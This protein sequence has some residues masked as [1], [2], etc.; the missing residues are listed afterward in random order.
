MRAIIY[1]LYGGLKHYREPSRDEVVFYY[2]PRSKIIYPLDKHLDGFD[3]YILVDANIVTGGTIMKVIRDLGLEM[4]RVIIRGNPKTRLAE[5]IVDEVMGD[6]DPDR[7]RIAIGFAGKAAS[8]KSFF[9]SALSHI[10]G[11]PM[12][13]I[14]KELAKRVDV[15]RYGEKLFDV[16]RRNPFVVG[17][18]IF[19]ILRRV[20][21]R[22]VIIDGLKTIETARFLSYATRRAMYIFFVE[23]GD[24]ELRRLSAKFRGDPDDRFFEERD[25][26]FEENLRKLREVSYAVID[27]LDWTTLKPLTELIRALGYRVS[28][29]C[30]FPNPFGSKRPLLEDYRRCVEKMVNGCVT[31]DT[32][33]SEYAFHTG[34]IRRLERRG[35]QLNERGREVV[36][37][38]ASA[39]R[40]VDDIL[41]EHR[42]RKGMPTLWTNEGIMRVIYIAILMTVKAYNICGEMG[43]GNKFMEMFRRVV[44]AVEYEL[45]VEDGIEVF[46]KFDD[47]LRAAEREAAFREFLA[48]L[49]GRQDL[50]NEFRAWGLRAQADDDLYDAEDEGRFGRPLFRREWLDDLERYIQD[51]HQS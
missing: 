32:D 11:I 22:V 9:A 44:N 8:M 4:E 16:E 30:G 25:S 40:I 14:G 1:I 48:H 24:E 27:S 5:G 19:P 29:I 10:H 26:L 41:D 46:D 34:Y 35:I 50:I 47:W 20:E 36:M 17:E 18:A 12:I 45:L 37:L 39:F 13:K 28:T 49:C 15:G 23:L 6:A 51:A 21:D 3:E 33:L 2:D 38:T 7:E 31:I 42:E 43:L